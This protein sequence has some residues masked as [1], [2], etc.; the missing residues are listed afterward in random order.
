M[1]SQ[2]IHDRRCQIQALASSGAAQSEI[3]AIIHVHPSTVCRELQR[4]A[5]GRGERHCAK[6][7]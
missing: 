7:A 5:T 4:N 2:L 1:H 3:A 6:E